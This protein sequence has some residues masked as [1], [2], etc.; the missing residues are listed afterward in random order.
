M[1]E[2]YRDTPTNITLDI[3]GAS[4]VFYTVL[5]DGVEV[6]VGNGTS[7]PLPFKIYGYDGQFE[8][9]WEFFVPGDNI[10]HTRYES[11]EIVTSFIPNLVSPAERALERTVRRSIQAYTGQE[12]GYSYGALAVEGN[13]TDQIRLPKRLID[14]DGVQFNVAPFVTIPIGF[15]NI[16]NDGFALS[17]AVNNNN[18]YGIK[19]APPEGEQYLANGVIYVPGTRRTWRKG[20]TYLVLGSWGWEGVP[21]DIA[22]AARVLYEDYSYPESEWRR[23]YIG[24][25][26]A[27][28]WRVDF[29][30]MAFIGTGNTEVDRLLDK[31]RLSG[32]GI[33]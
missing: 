10:S 24:A 3:P 29:K 12:F 25:I 8:V 14:L 17:T 23:R 4:D 1:A 21:E 6:A 30:D 18:Y 20:M 28:D 13:D 27:G 26:R 33:I 19:E 7:I 2:I 15:V 5:R 9:R 31:Y 22:E 11:H 32:V 16:I